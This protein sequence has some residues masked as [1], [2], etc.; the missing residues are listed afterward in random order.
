MYSSPS[1]GYSYS[2]GL[3]VNVQRAL[4]S[5][6][7]YKGSVDGDIGSGSRSAIRAYQRDHGLSVSG[8]IDTALL[9]SL[10]IG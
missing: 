2:D 6:G 3:A 9:R 8:R 5:R 10:R 7:Y 4:R 1:S